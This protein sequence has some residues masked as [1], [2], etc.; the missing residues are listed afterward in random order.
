MT[1]IAEAPQTP[2]TDPVLQALGRVSEELAAGASIALAVLGDRLGLYQALAGSGPSTPSELAARTGCSERLI[3]EWLANQAAGG[4]IAYEP[5]TGRFELD[6]AHAAILAHE[7]SPV[8][9][10]GSLQVTAALFAGLDRLEEAF[11]TDGAIDW[12]EHHADL[13]QGVA[14]FFGVACAPYLGD[15]L[16]A[17]PGA[18]AALAE[19]GPVLDL[20]CGQGLA[21]LALAQEHGRVRVHGVDA[22]ADSVER[23]RAAATAAGLD[24]RVEFT[25]ATADHLPEGPFA[26]ALALDCLHDMGDPVGA[27]AAVRRRL[28][29]GG[30]LLV[31][32]PAAGD[33]LEEN[34][35]PVGRMYYATSTGFCTPCALA[36]DGGWALG[37]QAGA[38]R[39]RDVLERAGFE[40]VDEI[41]RT[42]WQLVLAAHG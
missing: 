21:A 38:A 8:F 2:E 29:P 1:E 14:R 16:A 35:H 34:L 25:C 24:D 41:A 12:G 18:A 11:R 4:W 13:H 17:V 31:V 26:V 27:A 39:L 33:R 6:D 37:N 15:W 10:G 7:G 40:H 22:H 32:E 5:D 30:S 9:L 3:R 36:Q 28:A 19:G 20:G 42:P 23:A